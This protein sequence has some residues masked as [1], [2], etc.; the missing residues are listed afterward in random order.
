VIWF[1]GILLIFKPSFEVINEG[2]ISH[3]ILRT[4][5]PSYNLKEN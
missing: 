3:G 1:S 2:G 4:I 5:S